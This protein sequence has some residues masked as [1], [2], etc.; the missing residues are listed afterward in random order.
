MCSGN[1][2]SYTDGILSG[3]YAQHNC[4]NCTDLQ[5]CVYINNVYYDQYN[6]SVIREDVI[7]EHSL[8]HNTLNGFL[9][10][11][12]VNLSEF[13]VDIR[14][15]DSQQHICCIFDAK[16]K[17]ILKH[18]Y[19]L[20]NFTNA[21][22][23]VQNSI[24]N[25]SYKND[26][27]IVSDKLNVTARDHKNLQYIAYCSNNT[28]LVV[29]SNTSNLESNVTYIKSSTLLKYTKFNSIASLSKQILNNGN[30][31]SRCVHTR[32]NELFNCSKSNITTED[33]ISEFYIQNIKKK[34]IPFPKKKNILYLLSTRDGGTPKTSFDLIKNFNLEYNCFILFSDNKNLSLYYSDEQKLI[35]T[36]TLQE[37]ISVYTHTSEE[38]DNVFIDIL[39]TYAIDLVHIRHIA[40]HSLSLIQGTNFFNIPIIYS[41]HDY[42]AVCPS[43]NLLDNKLQYC[44]GVC[45]SGD[46]GSSC[47][48]QLWA[49]EKMPQLKNCFIFRWQKFF[50]DFLNYCSVIVTT[51]ESTKSIYSKIYPDIHNKIQIIEHGR[52]IVYR[53]CWENSTSKIKVLVPGIITQAKGYNEILSIK[54]LDTLNQIEF[55]FLG[56]TVIDDLYKT[57]IVHGGYNRDNIS[58]FIHTIKPNIALVLSIWPETYCHVLTEMWCNG[59][60]TITY[61]YGAQS[62]RSHQFGQ[63]VLPHNS[64][65]VYQTLVDFL[66]NK[67]ALYNQH[68]VLYNKCDYVTSTQEMSYRYKELYL[69]QESSV[70][71]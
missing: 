61:D 55:H 67:N 45:T 11:I 15:V 68:A 58:E 3:W 71:E 56:D 42:Y 38:Y 50:L 37:E 13:T 53:N 39:Y 18:S 2:E 70:F 31:I 4:L 32:Y 7:A 63:I 59:I 52:D 19:F 36:Y 24:Y 16:Q 54:K 20:Y 64:Y 9:I 43:H 1:I 29:D 5:F 28:E 8:N 51:S 57:G 65:L 69:M 6:T 26:C 17:F 10:K 25:I 40:W 14:P 35:G 27:I 22:I 62:L 60:P 46:E 48:Q 23:E 34:N 30:G 21:E 47:N 44:G 41:M 66:H 33:Y 49:K 12:E